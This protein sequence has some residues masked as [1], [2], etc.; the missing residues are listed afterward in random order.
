MRFMGREENGIISR[1]LRNAY[2]S[3]VISISLVLLLAQNSESTSNVLADNTDLSKFSRSS[4]SHLSNTKLVAKR[5]KQAKYGGKLLLVGLNGGQQV[6][7]I[8][9]TKFNGL[10]A[11][12]TIRTLI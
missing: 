11:G 1:R 2:M 3:T 4:S 5:C 8:L 9:L 7:L 10:H 12:Y 6:I